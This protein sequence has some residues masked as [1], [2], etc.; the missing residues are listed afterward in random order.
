MHMC[1]CDV[2]M[3]I[4][5]THRVCVFVCVFALSFLYLGTPGLILYL[6]SCEFVSNVAMILGEQ[7]PQSYADFIHFIHIPGGGKLSSMVV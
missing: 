3:Y 5:I 4:C 6:G 1:T 2:C 7:M